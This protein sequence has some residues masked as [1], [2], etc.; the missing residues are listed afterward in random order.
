[1]VFPIRSIPDLTRR[2]GGFAAW[3]SGG[4]RNGPRRPVG[5]FVAC[6]DVASSLVLSE[7]R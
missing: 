3:R 2:T 1:M 7:I 6:G 5:R 4:A